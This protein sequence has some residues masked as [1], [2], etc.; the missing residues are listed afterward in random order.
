MLKADDFRAAAVLDALAR[1]PDGAA[2]LA[3][4]D[5]GAAVVGGFV[6]D[7]LL[8]FEPREVDVVVDGDAEG[9][10]RRLGG[11][12]V[13]HAAFGTARAVKDGWSIDVA[14]ARRESYPR[15]GALPVVEPATLAEDLE[16]RDFGANAIAVP[17]AGGE[18]VAAAGALDDLAARRLRVLHE[19]SF[20][21]DPTRV[22]RLSRYRHRLD[23]TVEAH[24]AALAEAAT[25]QTVSGPRI[26]AELRLALLEP[27]PL[28]PLADLQ[29]L[30]PIVVDRALVE[31]ALALA[32]ADA[33][34][35]LVILGSIAGKVAPTEWL[36]SLE[37]TAHEREVL[38]LAREAERLAA[39]IEAAG[40]AS[41]LRDVLRRVPAEVVAM[42]GALGPAGAARRWLEEL[43]W[44][45][46]EIAGD[47]LLA[48]GVAAGPDLGARLER[49]LRRK[50][51]GELAAGRASEL[52]SALEESP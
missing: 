33:D 1:R 31:R 43:R 28:A 42:A 41:A 22:M 32:P 11:S 8:G 38:E 16:R 23:F 49:T 40:S 26:G 27:D 3:L 44:V 18:L 10:A 51:D 20:I 4:S 5:S 2:L 47:D 30:L 45:E 29:G 21:D 9:F 34:R 35:R 7:T 12:V 15:P 24:T 25:L 14:A 37:L 46:L 39:E 19:R 36:A 13:T 50:L 6:R 52:A 17:L 48:A